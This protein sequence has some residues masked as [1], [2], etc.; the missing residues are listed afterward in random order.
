M[1]VGGAIRQTDC[2]GWNGARCR[3]QPPDLLAKNQTINGDKTNNIIPVLKSQNQLIED[4]E[5]KAT[6]FRN[7]LQN[8][9]SCPGDPL[10]DKD[11]KTIVDREMQKT[12]YT[13]NPTPVD[14]PLTRSVTIEEI[15]THLKKTKKTKHQH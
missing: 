3:H 5:T 13:S 4:N 6:L 11:W 2:N 1:L 12:V 7:H 14:H 8:V 9:H 15:K 10:F